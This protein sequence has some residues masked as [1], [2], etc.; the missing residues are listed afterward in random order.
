MYIKIFLTVL[1]FGLC[2]TTNIFALGDISLCHQ[3][4]FPTHV[5]NLTERK[6]GEAMY[7]M[8]V[9]YLHDV[10]KG[11][12]IGARFGYGGTNE[13]QFKTFPEDEAKEIDGKYTILSHYIMLGGSYNKSVSEKVNWNSNLFLGCSWVDFDFKPLN[14]T[15]SSERISC[16]TSELSTGV[17][18]FFT[19][20]FRV[21]LDVGYRY[22]SEIEP[23]KDIK[24]DFS[25]ATFALGLS[26]KI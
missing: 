1:L 8:Q 3:T 6:R 22:T 11:F 26:Y 24:L 4:I 19:K 9:G 14:Y 20:R 5:K 15:Y 13:I 7:M 17:Q 23:L 2:F 16:F 25:G 12:K 18:Y 10:R 21:G